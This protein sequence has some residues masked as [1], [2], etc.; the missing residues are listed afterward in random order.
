MPKVCELNFML[1]QNIVPCGKIICKWQ[2][3]VYNACEHCSEIDTTRHMLYE[4]P[5]VLE[6]WNFVSTVINVNVNWKHIIC[7]FP[8]YDVP[9]QIRPHQIDILFLGIFL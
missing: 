5:H 1:F 9:N 4:C 7:G 6:I 3:D 2:K 8:K